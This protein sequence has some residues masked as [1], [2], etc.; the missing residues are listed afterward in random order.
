MHNV[1]VTIRFVCG[2]SSVQVVSDPQRLHLLLQRWL[3]ESVDG[4]QVT[5]KME[6]TTAPVCA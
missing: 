3:R 2:A 6:R 4:E 5:L 1:K